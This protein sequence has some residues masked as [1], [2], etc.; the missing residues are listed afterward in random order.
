[1]VVQITQTLGGKPR[2]FDIF[3]NRIPKYLAKLGNLSPLETFWMKGNS[4]GISFSGEYSIP[5]ILN[6]APL[7]W[8]LKRPRC[9]RNCF[10]KKNSHNHA[11]F[12]AMEESGG[13]RSYLIDDLKGQ[14]YRAYHF[15]TDGNESI[16]LFS[17]QDNRQ[18]GCVL[19]SFNVKFTGCVYSIY[20]LDELPRELVD[21]L[22]M[23]VVYFNNWNNFDS[24][25]EA[26]E[27][28][29]IKKETNSCPE[30]YDPDWLP[31]NFPDGV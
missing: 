1:M 21:L 22:T 26:K 6:V 3:Y 20:L 23:F 17:E 9:Y 24:V 28:T 7:R 18:I 2:A 13:R 14:K 30:K 12:C 27:G 11:T 10:I 5:P 29:P 31:A 15:N 16:S 19:T 8:F 4:K 25:K